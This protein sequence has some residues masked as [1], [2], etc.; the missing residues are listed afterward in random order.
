M[1]NGL[2]NGIK[3]FIFELTGPENQVCTPYP[4]SELCLL[5][6]RFED[7]DEV[8]CDVLDVF[9]RDMGVLRPK[10][11]T[12][13]NESDIE[14]IMSELK[15]IEEGF[16][17]VS[18]RKINGSF[19]RIKIKNPRYL[20]ISKMVHAG[21][22]S[23]MSPKYILD[24]I[25]QGDSD[26]ILTYFPEFTDVFRSMENKYKELVLEIQTVFENLRTKNLDPKGFASE[27]LNYPYHGLLFGLNNGKI[28]TVQD[29]LC[30]IAIDKLIVIL[31]L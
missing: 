28:K 8:D 2:I 5:G 7:L 17:L 13:N 31:G 22:G 18:D 12:F 1:M 27:A 3:T 20:A 19:L 26:E 29:G 9:A 6:A 24:V 21:T 25:R 15:D 16:V 11:Y 4:E 14:R 30:N 10:V 23:F